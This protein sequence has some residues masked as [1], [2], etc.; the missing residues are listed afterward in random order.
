METRLPPFLQ[1][2]FAE[3]GSSTLMGLKR[4]VKFAR[5]H[6]HGWGSCK[7][8]NCNCPSYNLINI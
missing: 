7:T 4:T 5:W 1:K 8:E 2:K 3:F 6:V